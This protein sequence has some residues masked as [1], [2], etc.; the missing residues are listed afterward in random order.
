MSIEKLNNLSQMM[1]EAREKMQREAQ[2]AFR[3]A[4]DEVFEAHPKLESFG[5][6]QYT[7]YFNDG[8]PCT[9][10]VNDLDTF[11]FG[12]VT[13][14]GGVHLNESV[15]NYTTN[16]YEPCEPHV[17]SYETETPA[18]FDMPA[19]VAAMRAVLV[20]HGFLESNPEIALG[21]FGDH[22]IVTVSRTGVDVTECAHD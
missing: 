2:E 5:W 21:A 7:P 15:Y 11:T 17:D 8:E 14:E 16:R 19:A 20:V 12:G 22:V 3:V 18:G 6:A 9:F 4:C 13:L 10:S 1:D